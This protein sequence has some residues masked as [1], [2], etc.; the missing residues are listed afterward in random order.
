MRTMLIAAAALLGFGSAQVL[1]SVRPAGETTQ[2]D[3]SYILASGMRRAVYD[4]AQPNPRF[5]Q[6]MP[7]AVRSQPRPQFIAQGI[8][9][10][11]YES[12]QPHPGAQGSAVG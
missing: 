4:G 10:A 8:P 9:A 2:V 5:A 11:V 6:G 3:T 7:A 1:A 12:G